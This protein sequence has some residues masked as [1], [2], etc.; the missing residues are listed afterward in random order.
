[1]KEFKIENRSYLQSENFLKTGLVSHG[2]TGS[3]GGVSKGK[4]TGLNLGF[5]VGDNPDFV[6]ENYRLVSQDLELDLNQMVLSKQTHT[7]NIRIVTKDD[8]GKGLTKISDIE[9]TD[10]LITNVKG[11]TLVVFTADCVPLLFLDPQKEVIAAVHAGWRGTVKGIGSKSLR[12]MEEKFGCKTE[13]ILV[14]AGP[15]IGSCCFEFGKDDAGVF[16]KENCRDI[17]NDKVLVDIW[18]I[19]KNQL[20]RCGVPEKNIDISGV[21]TVCNSDKFY[22]FR[23]HRENTGRQGAVISLKV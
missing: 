22:S 17:G 3:R 4:I 20:I 9:D 1:M 14:A 5:R 16:P 11:I 8:A 15:S 10:G 13:N 7:D 18:A 23:T 21:C 6:M 2:F 19:N 12:L